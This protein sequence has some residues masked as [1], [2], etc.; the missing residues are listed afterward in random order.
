MLVVARFVTGVSAAFMTPAAMSI[1]TTSYPEGPRRD[2]ALLVFAGVGAGGFS[3]GLVI[4][5]LLTELG[6]RWVFF[7][8]VFL[9]GAILLAALRLVPAEA[10]AEPVQRGFDLAGATSAAAA[11]LLFAYGIVRL[12][13]GGEGLGLSRRAE[14]PPAGGAFAGDAGRV[15]VVGCAVGFPAQRPTAGSRRDG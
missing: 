3:L 11:M 15:T 6:W 5:G 7:A 2:K 13:H 14:L 8:P 12:E 10:R 9:A 1:I 4:G